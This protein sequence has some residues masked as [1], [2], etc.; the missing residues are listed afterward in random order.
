MY[1]YIKIYLGRRKIV[2]YLTKFLFPCYLSKERVLEIG[3]NK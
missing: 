1:L 3:K 2:K